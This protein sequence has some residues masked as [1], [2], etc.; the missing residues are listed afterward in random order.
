MKSA[1]IPLLLL[2]STLPVAAQ[3]SWTVDRLLSRLYAN[4]KEYRETLPALECD[5]SIITQRV[6]DGKV[7]WQVSMDAT[8]R[9]L[10]NNSESDPFSD[11]Y[12]FHLID[13]KPPKEHFKLPYFVSG[14]FAN[15][16]GF[17][18]PRE[19]GCY[20][21]RLTPQDGGTRLLLEMSAKPQSP[22]PACK[23]IFEGYRKTMLIDAAGGQILHLTRT[24]SAKAAKEHHEVFFLSIDYAPQRLGDDTFWLPARFQSHDAKDEGRM[25]G[26]F[27]SCHLY[28]GEM[29]ILPAGSAPRASQ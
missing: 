21:Y 27:S 8:V 7:K 13:G 12:T 10:H 25:T 2:F 6:K 17:G 3:R 11:R 22:L 18:R 19:Q 5:E 26:S 1:A 16:L 15:G 9:E 28:I 24:M 20:D 4:A 29:K 14:V 23:D